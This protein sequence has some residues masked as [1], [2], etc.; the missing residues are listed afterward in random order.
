VPADADSR[1]R[2]AA[3]DRVDSAVIMRVLD[4]DLVSLIYILHTVAQAGLD[5]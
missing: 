3:K 4:L 5:S 1:C 2:E